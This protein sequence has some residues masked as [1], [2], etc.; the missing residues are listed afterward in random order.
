MFRH[1]VL[2]KWTDDAGEEQ[3]AEVF[4]RLSELPGA[5][6][7][8]RRYEFGPDAGLADDNFDAAAVADFDSPEDYVVYRDHPV[9][10]AA[11]KESIVPILAQRVAIQYEL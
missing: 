2:L 5:I 7:E 8:I 11:I 4:R 9:H 6:P 1:I 3:K 10:I